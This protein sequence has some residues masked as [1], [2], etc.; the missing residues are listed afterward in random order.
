MVESGPYLALSGQS[1][2]YIPD[3]CI[4]EAFKVVAK[5]YYQKASIVSL[6]KP[7]IDRLLRHWISMD[8]TVLRQVERA[9]PVNDTPKKPDTITWPI[10]FSK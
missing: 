8:H 5:K 1:R 7:K 10:A 2:I 3:L 4:S 9:V 6:Q